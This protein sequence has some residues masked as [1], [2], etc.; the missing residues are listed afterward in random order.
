MVG[1]ST[2]IAIV[3]GN[4]KTLKEKRRV[5]NERSNHSRLF[6]DSAIPLQAE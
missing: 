6:E 4:K 3:T 5:H 2:G 1:V